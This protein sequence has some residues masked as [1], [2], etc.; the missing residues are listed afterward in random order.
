MGARESNR[1]KFLRPGTPSDNAFIE[2]FNSRFREEFLNLN[3][4]ENI[5]EAQLKADQWRMYYNN[6]RPH[7]SLGNKTPNEFIKMVRSVTFSVDQVM[8]VRPQG[9]GII[10]RIVHFS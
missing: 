4:F 6:E 9:T 1:V 3:H 8:G 2:S 10:N 5:D 7:G